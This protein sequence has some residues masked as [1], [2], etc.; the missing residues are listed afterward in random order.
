MSDAYGGIRKITCVLAKQEKILHERGRRKRCGVKL[1]N[2]DKQDILGGTVFLLLLA[3]S[4][5]LSAFL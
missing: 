1:T 2:E 5:F 4:L 3:A